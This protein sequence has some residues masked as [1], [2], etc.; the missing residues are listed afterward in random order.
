MRNTLVNTTARRTR[1]AATAILAASSLLALLSG[2]CSSGNGDGSGPR[3]FGS[4]REAMEALATA[5]RGHD[6]AQLKAIMGPAGDQIISSGDEVDDRIR[7]ENF[8]ELYDE[9]HA[10]VEEVEDRRTLIVGENDWPFPVPIVRKNGSWAFDAEEGREE[11]L[12]RR[13]GENELAAIEVCKAI[14][15]AQREYA[16]RDPEQTGLRVYAR[17][18]ASEPG[19]RNGLYWPAADDEEPSPLGE[20]AAE[21]VEKGYRRKT[22]GPTAYHGYYYRILEG[23]GPNA[24]GGSIDYVIDGHMRLGFAVLAYP[25]EY[26]S[27]GVMTFMM[28]SDGSLYQQNLGDDTPKLVADIKS[29]DPDDKWK[30]VE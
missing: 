19:K 22:E 25:A 4:P 21:A 16:L 2:G 1:A 11:I 14:G 12:N 20:L 18:F 28:H 24:P 26:G 27:S 17:Q 9:R 3:T 15:D 30:K 23:Q 5:A 13:I 7:R 6:I 29:F 8:M 10:L